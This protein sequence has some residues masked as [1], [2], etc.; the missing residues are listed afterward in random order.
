MRTPLRTVVRRLHRF[1]RSLEELPTWRPAAALS[2]LP[3][4]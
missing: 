2:L 3:I 4:L 1:F